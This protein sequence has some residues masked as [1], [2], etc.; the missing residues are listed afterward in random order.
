MSSPECNYSDTPHEFREDSFLGLAEPVDARP[1][2]QGEMTPQITPADL[3]TQNLS[4][5]QNASAVQGVNKA[6]AAA[7]PSRRT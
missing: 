5:G 1:A 4:A 2:D 6:A 3:T 7:V